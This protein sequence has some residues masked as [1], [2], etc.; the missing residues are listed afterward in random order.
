MSH[1]VVTSVLVAVFFASVLYTTNGCGGS[2]TGPT[3]HFSSISGVVTDGVSG[4][5]IAG[6]TI[7]L[8]QSGAPAVTAKSGPDGRYSA[9]ALAPGSV[10][11]D[12]S[13][14]GYQPFSISFG[15]NEGSNSF[16]IALRPS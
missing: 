12:A 15:L 9:A 4:A 7:T 14:P 1:R 3:H 11:L 5:P 8:Q 6:A 16:N 10:R 13:A 2:V